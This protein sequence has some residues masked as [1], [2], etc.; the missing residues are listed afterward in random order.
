MYKNSSESV[1]T[2]K[3][4]NFKCLYGI[5]QEYNLLFIDELIRSGRIGVSS[6]L[7]TQIT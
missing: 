4:A 5:R 1:K 7:I 3:E 6:H 2:K